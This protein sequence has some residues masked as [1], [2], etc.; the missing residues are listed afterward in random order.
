MNATVR[1]LGQILLT[2]GDISKHS[3]YGSGRGTEAR[4]QFNPPQIVAEAIISSAYNNLL[5]QCCVSAF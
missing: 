4:S 1:I 2:S 5:Q 3:S